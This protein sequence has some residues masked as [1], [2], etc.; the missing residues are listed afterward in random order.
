[1]ETTNG[2]LRG[3]MLKY[4]ITAEG[5]KAGIEPPSRAYED[6]AG[7]DLRAL[8]ASVLPPQ[9]VT[10]VKTGVGFEIPKG[11]FGLICNRT[12]GGR[13]GILPVGHVVDAGYTGEIILILYNTRPAEAI[14]IEANER[15]A[16]MVV[17]PVYAGA[18]QRIEAGDVKQTERGAKRLGSSGTG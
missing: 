16:Q 4:Y 13:R 6:D 11:F 1:M 8:Y 2:K 14:H 10:E 3:G 5:S 15:I 18:L 9:S 12:S 7:I 17:M